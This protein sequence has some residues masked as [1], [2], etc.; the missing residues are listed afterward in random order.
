MFDL[1]DA[2]YCNNDDK[3]EGNA[4]AAITIGTGQK[5]DPDIISKM[6]VNYI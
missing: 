6:K 1:N 5:S 4:V 2:G 3:V